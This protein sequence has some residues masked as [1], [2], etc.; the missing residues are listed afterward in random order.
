MQQ[1]TDAIPKK[2]VSQQ[3]T[4]GNNDE[5]SPRELAMQEIEAQLNQQSDSQPKPEPEKIETE[6]ILPAT[7]ADDQWDKVKVKVKVDGQVVE[8][9]L[10]EVTKGYQKDAVASRR[11]AQAAEERKELEARKKEL[12][13]RE[14]LLKAPPSAGPEA[15]DD[16]DVD[17]QIK[18]AMSALVEGDEDAA[19]EALKSILKGRRDTSTTPVIDEEAL[20]T[21]AEQRIEGKRQAEENA[22]AWDEFIGTSP[23]FADQTSKERQ[24]GDYLFNTKYGPQIESG[25]I[26]YR[27]ALTQAAQDVT[28]VFQQQPS[29]QPGVRQ[30]AQQRKAAIDNLPTAGA[31]AVK[32]AAAEQT[33]DDI[34]TEMRQM[35]GQPV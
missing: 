32:S 24:Y 10:S 18:V 30:Q 17:S 19:A 14:T 27:E 13:D 11:L 28:A 20:L 4:G 34:L 5:M 15:G 35:R 3:D 33:T 26:S 31:R 23:A 2:D 25:E 16:K 29:P 8:L 1:P 12:D 6:T 21:K 22:K 9:P 7:L